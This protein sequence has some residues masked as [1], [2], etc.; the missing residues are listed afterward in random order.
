MFVPLACSA[1]ILQCEDVLTALFVVET[2]LEWVSC[3]P[4]IMR[5]FPS[6]SLSVLPVVSLAALFCLFHSPA[7]L[8]CGTNSWRRRDKRGVGIDG[9]LD[10]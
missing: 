10:G 4:L 7:G 1:K 6:V 9:A 3:S 5:P 2:Q 8:Q